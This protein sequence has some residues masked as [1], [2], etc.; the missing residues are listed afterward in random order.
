MFYKIPS[1]SNINI[2]HIRY[3][4]S[5]HFFHLPTCQGFGSWIH[6]CYQSLV[7]SGNRGVA[8][9]VENLSDGAVWTLRLPFS[10]LCL[11]TALSID[12]V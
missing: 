8:D 3:M 7:V 5:R 4:L 9:T 11:Y 6:K 12:Q 10:I 2:E 1:I